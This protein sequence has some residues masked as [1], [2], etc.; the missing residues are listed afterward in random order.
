MKV[1]LTSAQTYS[2]VPP[3]SARVKGTSDWSLRVFLA[4]ASVAVARTLERIGSPPASV[5]TPD[6]S[7]S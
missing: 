3:P 7:Q 5:G 1:C 4:P 6:G 2:V